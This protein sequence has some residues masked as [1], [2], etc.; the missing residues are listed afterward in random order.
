MSFYLIKEEELIFIPYNL[1]AIDFEFITTRIIE[2]K[3]KKYFQE[4]IEAGLVLKDENGLEGYSAI[5]KPRNLIESKNTYKNNI[6]SERFS[7]EEIKNGV[8]LREVLDKIDNMYNRGETIWISWG[9]AEYD[10]LKKLWKYYNKNMIRF[11]K[12]Y[13]DLSV[14]LKRFYNISQNLSLDRALSY[15]DISIEERH[16]ALPD[17]R[18]LINIIDR[19][20]L[21]GYRLN[22]E[23]FEFL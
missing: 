13:L 23:N 10:T 19:M 21:D 20:F 14:E 18:A 16:R 22:E 7:L 11:K 12:Y 15:L 3:A 1:L 2:N 6:F 5:V 9:K 8:D 17:A 4:I